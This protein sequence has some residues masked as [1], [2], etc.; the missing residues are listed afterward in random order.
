MQV[1]GTGVAWFV[2]QIDLGRSTVLH[3][4]IAN[5]SV[6][7]LSNSNTLPCHLDPYL[8][9]AQILQ[10]LVLRDRRQLY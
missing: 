3:Q 6:I 4:K 2:T 5:Y 8:D 10:V 9:L 7:F 1:S